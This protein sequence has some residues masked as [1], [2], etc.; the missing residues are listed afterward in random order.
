MEAFVVVFQNKKE[1]SDKKVVVIRET[2]IEKAFKVA[3]ILTKNTCI[4]YKIKSISE[5]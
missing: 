1:R 4:N 2:N 5:S 3:K